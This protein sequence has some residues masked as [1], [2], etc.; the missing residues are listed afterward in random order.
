M[1]QKLVA[2][3]HIAKEILKT[4]K[5]YVE[6]LDVLREVGIAFYGLIVARQ[7]EENDLFVFLMY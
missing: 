2:R 1:D 4:E 3:S 6:F 7:R 5:S